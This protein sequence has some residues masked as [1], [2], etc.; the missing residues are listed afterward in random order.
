LSRS[1]TT[2]SGAHACARKVLLG[3]SAGCAYGGDESCSLWFEYIYADI[4]N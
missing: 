4:L 2:G 3:N 1:V